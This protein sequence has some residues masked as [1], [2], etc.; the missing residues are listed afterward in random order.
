MK[1]RAAILS[2]LK[3][4]LQQLQFMTAAM[5]KKYSLTKINAFSRGD[6]RHKADK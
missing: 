2:G 1:T 4:L 5:F 3:S 6:M